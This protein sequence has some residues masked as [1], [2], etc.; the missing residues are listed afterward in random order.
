MTI[1]VEVRAA[2]GGAD[3]KDLVRDQVGIYLRC[4]AKR[5][6]GVELVEDRLGAI[7]LRVSGDGAAAAFANEAGGHRWQHVPKSAKG[8]VQTST[9]TIAVL[10]EPTETEVRLDPRDLE[11]T[12]CRGQGPGG[13]ARNTTDSAVQIKHKPSG[14]IVRCDI[15]RSQHANKV[16]AMELLRTRL[17][18]AQQEVSEREHAAARKLQVGAGMRGEK[19]RTARVQDDQ[20]VDH[21]TGRRWRFSDYQKGA[22]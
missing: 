12:V 5:G 21:V 2:A 9:I 20:V 16:T 15:G 18:Q 6:L 14:L 22:L 19:R 4:C 10:P 1:M 13:Q 11:I 7:T 17:W 8:R 3:A